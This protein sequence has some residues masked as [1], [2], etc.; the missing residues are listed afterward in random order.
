[1][2]LTIPEG[3]EG[4]NVIITQTR[5]DLDGVALESAQEFPV[6]RDRRIAQFCEECPALFVV[7]DDEW[8]LP[9]LNEPEFFCDSFELEKKG[10]GLVSSI[11]VKALRIENAFR[12][13]AFALLVVVEVKVVADRFLTEEVRVELKS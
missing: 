6:E 5:W 9:V 1:M 7:G 2:E 12:I 4:A 8:N 11:K 3:F 13:P 10:E